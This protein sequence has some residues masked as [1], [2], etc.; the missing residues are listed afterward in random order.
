MASIAFVYDRVKAYILVPVFVKK[1]R[2]R[3]NKVLHSK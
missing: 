1:S 2:F 3:S